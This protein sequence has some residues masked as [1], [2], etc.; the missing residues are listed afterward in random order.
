MLQTFNHSAFNQM[1]MFIGDIS[2]NA[3]CQH[4]QSQ[5]AFLDVKKAQAGH[6]HPYVT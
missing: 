2:N 5:N 6:M 3:L 4:F 1:A